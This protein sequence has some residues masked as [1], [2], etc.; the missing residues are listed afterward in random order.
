MKCGPDS[1]SVVVWKFTP[2]T[3]FVLLSGNVTRKSV[4]EQ[5][6]V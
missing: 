6:E 2:F 4:S 3:D 1:G 5:N